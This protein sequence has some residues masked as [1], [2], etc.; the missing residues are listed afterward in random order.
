[1]VKKQ[2]DIGLKDMKP[3]NSQEALYGSNN[4]DIYAKNQA[5]EPASN[6]SQVASCKQEIAFKPSAVARLSNKCHSNNASPLKSANSSQTST[7]SKTNTLPST[8]PSAVSVLVPKKPGSILAGKTR[9]SA[10]EFC[11]R[12]WQSPE[13]HRRLNFPIPEMTLPSA[14]APVMTF[15]PAVNESLE[16]QSNLYLAQQSQQMRQAYM[17]DDQNK[18]QRVPFYSNQQQMQVLQKGQQPRNSHQP[19]MLGLRAV[20]IDKYTNNGYSS[21]YQN[22][23]VNETYSIPNKQGPVANSTRVNAAEVIHANKKSR[24][25]IVFSE[26]NEY[27]ND[28][29][30]YE[31]QRRLPALPPSTMPLMNLAFRNATYHTWDNNPLQNTLPHVCHSDASMDAAN[32]L[33]SD[34]STNTCTGGQL[35]YRSNDTSSVANNSINNAE[36][37]VENLFG[38]SS[39]GSCG[40]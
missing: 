2:N 32:H 16:N 5:F 36:S 31:A 6:S 18:Q 34:S 4:H 24:N 9:P 19:Q 7:P 10:I 1:M 27:E 20:W 33:H 13:S 15:H 21:S 38:S 35:D 25:L 30:G 39:G 8:L 11:T 12:V 23:I 3:L 28:E 22:A 40:E 17:P 14:Q 37:S 29:P 26:Y